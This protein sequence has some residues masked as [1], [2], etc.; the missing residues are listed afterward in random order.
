MGD[1]RWPFLAREFDQPLEPARKC[2]DVQPVDRAGLAQTRNV[3]DDQAMRLSELRD[4][5]RPVD[6]AALDAAMQQDERSTLPAL[7]HRGRDAPDV[8]TPLLHLDPLKELRPGGAR[9]RLPDR[10]LGFAYSSHRFLTP[11]QTR[12][13]GRASLAPAS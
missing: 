1:E 7:Q 4:D 3:G 9:A 6:A 10:E 13:P 11:A 12:E 8:H 2:A 5:G